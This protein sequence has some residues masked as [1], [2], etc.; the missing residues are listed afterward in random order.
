VLTGALIVLF[1]LNVSHKVIA[2]DG[3]EPVHVD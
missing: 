2:N 3:K 1:G